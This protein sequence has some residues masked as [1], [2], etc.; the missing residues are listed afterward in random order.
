MPRAKSQRAKGRRAPTMQLYSIQQIREILPIGRAEAY[1]LARRLGRRLGRKLYV[2]PSVL[3]DWLS[4]RTPDVQHD[5]DG[6]T[7]VFRV[8]R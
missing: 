4:R 3:E 5:D 2:V 6:V 8:R 1:A 7:W